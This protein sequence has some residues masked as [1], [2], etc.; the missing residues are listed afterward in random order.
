VIGKLLQSALCITLAPLL[1]AQQIGQSPEP[2]CGSTPAASVFAYRTS[3]RSD[4]S[5][6]RADDSG[7]LGGLSIVPFEVPVELTPVDPAAWANAT[8]GS[9]VTFRVV[10]DV[11]Q[12][13]GVFNRKSFYADA[14]A[15]TLIEGKVIRLR[16]GK[17]R[18][19]NGKT[20]PRVREVLVGK[21]IKLELENS[22]RRHARIS[23]LPR[24]LVVW[25]VHSVIAVGEGVLFMILFPIFCHSGCDL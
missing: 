23:S 22:P 10:R 8:L 7:S 5:V 12:G 19:R 25:P 16:E 15:G 24:N 1:A 20:E 18:T 21:R 9:T 6:N 17:L 4:E 14:Y 11:I 2:A 13:G 3:L